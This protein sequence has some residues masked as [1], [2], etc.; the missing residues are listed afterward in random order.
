MCEKKRFAQKFTDGRTDG[1]TTDAS[2]IAIALA[3]SRNELN[4]SHTVCAQCPLSDNVQRVAC[5]ALSDENSTA[6]SLS[7]AYHVLNTPASL[8]YRRH[9]M[10]C[11]VSGLALTSAAVHR[12]STRAM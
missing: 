2:P 3:H 10:S 6:I 12:H 11:I 5:T 9:L 8:I 7:V 1:Q 4:H